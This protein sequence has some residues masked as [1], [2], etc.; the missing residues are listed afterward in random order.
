MPS[1][2]EENDE[3]EVYDTCDEVKHTT[4]PL[5]VFG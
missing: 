4:H 1:T 3:V 5:I 2:G